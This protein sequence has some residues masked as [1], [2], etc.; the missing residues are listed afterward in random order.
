MCLT[1]SRSG[2]FTQRKIAVKFYIFKRKIINKFKENDVN[3][4]GSL[5]YLLLK[6]KYL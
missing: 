1:A 4:H 3:K 6:K 2:H 5:L